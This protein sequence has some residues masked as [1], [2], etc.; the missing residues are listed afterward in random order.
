MMMDETHKRHLAQLHYDANTTLI[1]AELLSASHFP[2][3]LE[4]G[5]NDRKS[6]TLKPLHLFLYPA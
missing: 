1:I 6:T 2:L 5:K 3:K 4:T